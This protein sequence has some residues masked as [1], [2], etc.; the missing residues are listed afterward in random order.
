MDVAIFGGSFD[1]FHTAHEKIVSLAL[2][3]LKI[4]KLF[5]IP[6]F[7]NPFKNSSFLDANIRLNLINELYMNEKNIEII[8]YE[9]KLN[10]K[11]STFNTVQY[12]KQK[13]NLDKIYLIIGADNLNEI[14]LWYNFKNLKNEVTFVV[15][16]RDDILIENKYIDFIHLKLEENISSS[17]LRK[18]MD[19]NYI[20]KK[21]QKK[22]KELWKIE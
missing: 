9:V 3:K 22:V 13:F 12:L 2:K 7:L 15:L 18:N 20:P 16:S 14:H 19:I 17:E 11:V 8:D 5:I 21:I 10:T 4:S 6:T 1:P